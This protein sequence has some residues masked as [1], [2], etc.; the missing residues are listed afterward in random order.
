MMLGIV[1]GGHICGFVY[2]QFAD[3]EQEANGLYTAGRVAKLE[4]EEVKGVVEEAERVY[5]EKLKERLVK[6]GE[7]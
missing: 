5:F 1:D 6:N 3:V 2:T 4:A 7:K